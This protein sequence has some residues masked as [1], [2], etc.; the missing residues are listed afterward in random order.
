MTNSLVSWLMRSFFSKI[1][2]AVG[3]MSW[4]GMY[5]RYDIV[6]F[7]TSLNLKKPL[8]QT[9][10]CFHKQVVEIIKPSLH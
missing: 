10:T 4:F 8:K 6:F 7:C 9:L 1:P 3:S 5:K 2:F